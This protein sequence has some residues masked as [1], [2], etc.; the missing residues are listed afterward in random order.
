MTRSILTAS[1]PALAAPFTFHA[2]SVTAS[3]DE[4]KRQISGLVIPYGKPGRTSAGTITAGKGSVTLPED[5]GRVKLMNKHRPE[6]GEAVGY[7]IACEDREDGIHATF[8]LGTGPLADAALAA[9]KERTRDALSV[10]LSDHKITGS[11]L[12][13]SMLDAVALV[14]VPAFR[15]ARVSA[16]ARQSDPGK[17]PPSLLSGN[18][19]TEGV[20]YAEAARALRAMLQGDNSPE[21]TAALADI[22]HSANLWV[23]PKGWLG[24]LWSG[25]PFN[26]RIVDLLSNKPLE[27]FRM[28][29]W[30]WVTR[31]EV[32]D[33]AGNKT[34]IPSN[35]ITTEE[36]NYT[37]AK[38]AGGHDIAREHYDFNDREFVDSYLRAMR[39]SYAR[40]TDAKAAAH[41]VANADAAMLADGVT[42]Q[43]AP[44]LIHA[45]Q[46]AIQAVNIGDAADRATLGDDAGVG[47]NAATYVLVNPTDK[48]T[49][50][51]YTA[52]NI[53][54]YL[55]EMLGISPLNFAASSQVPAGTVI[56]GVKAA[57]VWRELPGSPLRVS[58]VDLARGGYDEA[59]F[60]YW[61]AFTSDVRA[62]RKVTI[63]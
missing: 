14:D 25:L 4:E 58:T 26:R 35:A 33:W 29:G 55:E 37:A 22:T 47:D 44:D 60:G 63:A 19:S 6:G 3:A 59:L 1:A 56:A 12:T 21:V 62:I 23:A 17:V 32:D 53:P 31:P 10:E 15:D 18:G 7:M 11:T 27:S 34:E 13:A 30:R 52:Q 49:L 39:D 40:K 38:L 8:Q 20:T 61:A 54:A 51:D 41:I 42:P 28:T 2:P 43:T 9:A 45:A 50:I 24:E 16:I 36:V 5:M 46:L 57:S 48:N